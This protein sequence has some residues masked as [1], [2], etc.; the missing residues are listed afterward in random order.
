MA[1]QKPRC[2]LR[3]LFFKKADDRGT[4]PNPHLQE[5][6]RSIC[7]KPPEI[8]PPSLISDLASMSN[9]TQIFGRGREQFRN[10]VRQVCVRSSPAQAFKDAASLSKTKTDPIL[11]ND[12]MEYNDGSSQMARNSIAYTGFD[13]ILIQLRN[14]VPNLLRSFCIVSLQ[15][16]GHP[17][18][19]ASKDLFLKDDL[20]EGQAYYLRDEI[21]EQPWVVRQEF[22]DDQFSDFLTIQGD[23]FEGNVE[24]KASHTFFGQLDLT[25]LIWVITG[26][27]SPLLAQIEEDPWL[28][29]A[30]EEMNS[31]GPRRSIQKGANFP[32]SAV[33]GAI[34]LLHAYYFI[35]RAS[36]NGYVVTHL[37]PDLI[38]SVGPKYQDLP[39]AAFLDLES[40]SESFESAEE[41]CTKILWEPSQVREWLYCVPNFCPDLDCWLCFMVDGRYECLWNLNG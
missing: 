39:S 19:V 30:N 21:V 23:L 9:D 40:L 26:G 6:S 15:L 41:F 20:A 22:R 29:I 3:K 1:G 25:A 8:P 13:E 38:G 2:I 33:V 12:H 34:R 10:L 27:P 7:Y 18:Q 4:M 5:P 32:E 28:S 16:P 35:V 17:V 37:A 36:D 14:H 11:N 24:S 31:R